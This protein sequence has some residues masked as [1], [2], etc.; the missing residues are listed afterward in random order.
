MNIVVCIK[1]VPEADEV[2]IDRTT[3]T[4]IRE[5]VPCAINPPDLNAL[6]EAL[7][8]RERFK[9]GEMGP[10]GSMPMVNVV[11]MGPPQVEAALRDALALGADRAVLLCDRAFAGADTLAT[12]YTLAAAIRKLWVG[13][14]VGSGSGFGDAVGA[15]IRGGEAGDKGSML[16]IC[17]NRSADG[18]TGHVGPQLAEK[19]GI[20][21]I[22]SVRRLEPLNVDS[23]ATATVTAAA[24]ADVADTA[25]MAGSA[26]S[27]GWGGRVRAE[28]LVDDGYEVVEA[29]LPLLVTVVKGMNSPRLPS[30]KGMMRAKKAAITVWGASDLDVDAGRVGLSGSATQVVRVF[31]PERPRGRGELITGAP[32]EQARKLLSRLREA[33]ML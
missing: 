13:D 12:S 1:Q 18:D 6:E 4:L 16:I 21:Y 7:R 27:K 3:G 25:D 33:R 32:G 20:P 8:I 11:S 23:T 26:G 17:G 24:A 31:E 30:L 28:R 5:G 9:P 2:K 29:P 14:G 15:G 10:M 22:T 19:L